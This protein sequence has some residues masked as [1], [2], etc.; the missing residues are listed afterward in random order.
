MRPP[1][2]WRPRTGSAW[3]SGRLSRRPGRPTPP[4]PPLP[5]QTPPCPP[6][7]RSPRANR[8][9]RRGE[10]P[11][12]GG[13]PDPPPARRPPRHGPSGVSVWRLRGGEDVLAGAYGP[14]A[15]QGEPRAPRARGL[16]L[17]PP[18]APGGPA[19]HRG[20]VAG[21][22]PMAERS[23]LGGG[24]V[25]PARAGLVRDPPRPDARGLGRRRRVALRVGRDSE[26][27][28]GRE[29]RLGGRGRAAA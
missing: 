8:G 1:S 13:R 11:S 2:A 20:V 14:G 18:D 6:P 5:P 16:G 3:S 25:G 7:Q 12:L 19:V 10:G 29:L 28:G 15:V 22:S 27:P 21:G 26:Q 9:M 4:P 17:L 24:R 23:G